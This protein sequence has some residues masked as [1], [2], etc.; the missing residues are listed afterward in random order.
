MNWGHVTTKITLIDEIKRSVKKIEKKILNPVLDFNVQL[1]SI[2]QN[3]G[4][5]IR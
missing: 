2:K 1:R 5:Y 3:R 4:N